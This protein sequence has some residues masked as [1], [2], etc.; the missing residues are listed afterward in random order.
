MKQQYLLLEDVED[1]GRSGEIIGAKPGFARNYL[2]PQKKA[3]T[4]SAHTLRMQSKLQE[5][6]AKKAVIDKE[7]A[8]QLATKLEGMALTITVKVD[9]EGHLYGSVT[10]TDIVH[11]FGKEGFHFERRNVI[12]LHPL[13]ELGIKNLTL[14]L[15][16]G[17]MCNYTLNI[18]SE[19]I[20]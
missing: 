19:V 20:S 13:K 8:E 11:L 14:K 16:E 6:R 17:V 18:V 15:K 4:A 9:P 12:L 5:E 10:Q 3:V 1:I 2:L 7:E